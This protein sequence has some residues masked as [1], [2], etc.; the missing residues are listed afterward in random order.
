MKILYVSTISNTVNAFLIPHIR[1]LV[2]Q[3]HQVDI[4]FNIVQ[5]VI[6]ELEQLGCKIHNIEFQRSPLK[7]EN[8]S[9]FRKIKK[10]IVNEGYNLVHTHTPIASFLTRLA[11]SKIPNLKILYTAH[12][13]HFFKGASLKNWLIYYMA[14]KISSRWTDGILTMNE[15]DFQSA[16]KIQS[17]SKRCSAFRIHGVGIDLKKFQPQTEDLKARLR[18]EY[19]YKS[20]QFILMYA[21]E[22]S[23]RKHQDLLIDTVKLLKYRVPKLKLL[24][25]GNGD[26]LGQYEKQVNEL[27][28][29]GVVEFLGYRKDIN[30]L[31]MISDI[32]VSS[33]RQEGLPVNVM[34]AMATSL[35][36]VV[37]DCRGN[38]D[39]VDD[40][41]NGYVVGVNDPEGFA[42][43]V[44]K[45]Y[46]SRDKRQRFGRMSNELIK[47]YSIENVL[48][49]I[50]KI[51][52]NYL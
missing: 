17:K 30:K 33:S 39:L 19:G 42:Y 29:E 46:I 41:A 38:R 23:F 24:L 43:A 48:I 7:K 2:N 14:E 3:G 20:E 36:L 6:P 18:Q 35:P 11:C 9:A 21:G 50:N 31:M 37:T 32:A 13:F 12:G 45:L 8:I 4:A 25:A 51:Y 44:E 5:E 52:K 28:L 22:L 40:G 47:N 15:E 1:M 26:L 27:G 49:E 34:E 10:L 16:I